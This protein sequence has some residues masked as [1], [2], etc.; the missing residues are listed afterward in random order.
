MSTSSS[1][2]TSDISFR[3]LSGQCKSPREANQ[4]AVSAPPKQVGLAFHIPFQL[5]E[6]III[7]LL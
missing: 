2:G 7:I 3:R 5:L 6:N 1:T 4:G